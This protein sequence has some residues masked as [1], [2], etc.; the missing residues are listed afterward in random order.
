M[1]NVSSTNISL[2]IVEPLQYS[3]H[4]SDLQIKNTDT[5][6]NLH[7]ENIIQHH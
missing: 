6:S 7:I 3:P 5:N 4:I 1:N 2:D